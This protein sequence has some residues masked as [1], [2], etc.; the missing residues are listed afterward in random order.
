VNP[1][2]V[3]LAVMVVACLAYAVR[4]VVVRPPAPENQRTGGH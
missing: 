2:L 4:L 3:V 1:A